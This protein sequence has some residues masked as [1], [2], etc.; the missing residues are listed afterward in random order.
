[1][2]MFSGEIAGAAGMYSVLP[3][4]ALGWLWFYGL[5]CTV[6]GV[7]RKNKL[8]SLVELNSGISCV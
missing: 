8:K 6:S 4:L 2:D 1:M 7:A 5:L 3:V